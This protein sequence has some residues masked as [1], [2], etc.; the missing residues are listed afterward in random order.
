[1]TYD[2]LKQALVAS[3]FLTSDMEH[4]DEA[5]AFESRTDCTKAQREAMG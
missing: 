1:M 4:R 2:E 5:V 3:T